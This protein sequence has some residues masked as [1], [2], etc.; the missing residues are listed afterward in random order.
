MILGILQTGRVSDEASALYGGYLDMFA[1]LF[2]PRG[3]EL[4]SGRWSTATFPEAPTR[5]MPG[6]SPARPMAFTR[7][8]LDRP[9]R[10]A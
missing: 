6:S 7:T 5:R 3:F 9:A 2:E 4:R 10:G 8:A 1:R